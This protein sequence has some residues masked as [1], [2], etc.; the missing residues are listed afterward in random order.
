[1]NINGEIKGNF[2]KRLIKKSD[3]ERSR[4]TDK[5]KP[6]LEKYEKKKEADKGKDESDL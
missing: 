4:T 1:M 6:L 3:D 2:W 5:M